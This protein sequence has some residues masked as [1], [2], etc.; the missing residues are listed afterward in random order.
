MEPTSPTHFTVSVSHTL[1]WRAVALGLI[2]IL[3]WYAG[4][5]L[6]VAFAGILLASVLRTFAEWLQR[7]THFSARW[8]YLVVVALIFGGA[9]TWIVLLGPQIVSQAAELGRV[10]P[11][12]IRQARADLSGYEWGR[13]ILL[14]VDRLMAHAGAAA[15]FGTWA[16]SIGHFLA[17]VIVI[18]AIGFFAGMNPGLYRRSLLLLIPEGRRAKAADVLD[19][20]GYTLRW[21]L[22]GQFVPM[23]VLGVGTFIGLW[24]LQIPS[25]FTLAFLTAIMLFI[26]YAG[27]I[28]ALIPT[29]LVALLQGTRQLLW[30]LALYVV[31]HCCE[32]Y[33]ITPIV[34]RRAVRLAPALTVFI[35]LLMW[36]LAGL[37]GLIVATPLG[38][39]CLVAVK[40]LYLERPAASD[41]VDSLSQS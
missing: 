21:W 20:I 13:F 31:V 24:I 11:Q 22:I 37:L 30:I 25:A 23:L 12:S 7:L 10:L 35:Q 41:S 29:A 4:E 17:T 8:S 32:G 36:K 28:A 26:P 19:G 16:N 15:P 3:L 1:L 34:Q 40:K 33:I 6:L 2:V 18:V 14:A 5:V 9:A 27:S 39:A 38:A